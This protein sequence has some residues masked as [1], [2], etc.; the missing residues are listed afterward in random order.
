MPPIFNGYLMYFEQIYFNQYKNTCTG[1]LNN[2]LH[3]FSSFNQNNYELPFVA[4]VA[5]VSMRFRSKER[6]PRV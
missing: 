6:G 5:S 4:C 1:V 2:G 3:R